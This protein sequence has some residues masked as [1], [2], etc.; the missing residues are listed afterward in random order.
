MVRL[1]SHLITFFQTSDNQFAGFGNQFE[2]PDGI[3]RC[4][5]VNRLI[6][7]PTLLPQT[8]LKAR[9]IDISRE[10]VGVTCGIKL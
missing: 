5:L 1:K 7:V 4:F 6:V 9:C 10:G 2:F 8:G 3:N